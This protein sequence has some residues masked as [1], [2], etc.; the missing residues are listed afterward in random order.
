M[1]LPSPALRR[2]HVIASEVLRQALQERSSLKLL[3]VVHSRRDLLSLFEASLTHSTNA[4]PTK[5][6]TCS[7]PAPSC[8][9]PRPAL[10]Y[11]LNNYLPN[12]PSE[13]TDPQVSPINADLKHLPPTTI[14]AAE[15]DPLQ[16]D[17]Q[18]YATALAEAGNAVIY[19]I[20]PGTTHE[21]FGTGAVVDLAKQAEKFAASRL[22]AS[23]K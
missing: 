10:P 13:A 2:K 19:R 3:R 18:A 5:P 23:F 6:P 15:L 8:P 4:S 7:T 11:F 14:I 22:A 17:G 21:F 12:E 9:S 16:S 1:H 20:Y